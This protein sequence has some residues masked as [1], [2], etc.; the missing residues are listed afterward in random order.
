MAKAAAVSIDLDTGEM[1]HQ[2]FDTEDGIDNPSLYAQ[3]FATDPKILADFPT[4]RFA[5]VEDEE[6][7]AIRVKATLK[8]FGMEEK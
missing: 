7:K 5:I 4:H 1:L 2:T 6:A 3:M 8:R